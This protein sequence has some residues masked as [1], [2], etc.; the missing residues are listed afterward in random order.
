[1]MSEPNN[2]WWSEPTTLIFGKAT[3]PTQPTDPV[4]ADEKPDGH[5]A[6]RGEG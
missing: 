1:M 3:I 6:V 5:G 2:L 4:F